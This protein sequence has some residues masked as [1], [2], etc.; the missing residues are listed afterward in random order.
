MSCAPSPLATSYSPKQC[1]S[2]PATPSAHSAWP[3]GSL[4]KL[5][6]NTIGRVVG[7]NKL[8]PTRPLVEILLDHRSDRMTNSQLVHLEEEPMLYIVDPAIDESILE[9]K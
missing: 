6:N 7:A 9:E 5:N 8:Y 1:A 4:V 3:L 2:A